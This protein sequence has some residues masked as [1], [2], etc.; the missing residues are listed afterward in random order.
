MRLSLLCLALATPALS[1]AEEPVRLSAYYYPWYHHDAKATTAKGAA[2]LRLW[3]NIL[4]ARP[5]P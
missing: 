1:Q 4:R 3:V 2:E 5:K